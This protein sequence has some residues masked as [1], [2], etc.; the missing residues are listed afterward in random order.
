MALKFSGGEQKQEVFEEV[1]KYLSGLGLTAVARDFSRPW[2]G[3]FVID[4]GQAREFAGIF[5]PDIEFASIQLNRKL[6]PKILIVQ[7][8]QRLSWQYHHRRSEIW[9]VVS[10]EAGVITSNTDVEGE[11]QRLVVGD[12][13]ELRQGQR[14]RLVGL[15]NW[16]I[17]AEIWQHTDADRPSDE[18]DIVRVQDDFGR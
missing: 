6:S 2:G 12:K 17:I 13:I 1:E 4:E 11:L 7:P 8:G 5:F 14:H 10:G 16:G 3:F 15:K 18:E 9:R